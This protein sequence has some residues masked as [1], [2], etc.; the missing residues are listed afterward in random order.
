MCS[1]STPLHSINTLRTLIRVR[2]RARV[3][4]KTAYV[5]SENTCNWVTSIYL[6]ENDGQLIMLMAE[7]VEEEKERLHMYSFSLC[8]LE[9]VTFLNQC[10]DSFYCWIFEM[11]LM[12]FVLIP[13]IDWIIIY[14][15]EK[16]LVINVSHIDLTSIVPWFSPI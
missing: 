8:W 12:K 13:K 3:C 4:L 7:D 6:Y 14:R 5:P 10:L 11:V 9:W 16:K 2:V 1:L 15:I